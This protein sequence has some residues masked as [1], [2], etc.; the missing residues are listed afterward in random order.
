[1]Q[2]IF[3]NCMLILGDRSLWRPHHVTT[4]NSEV[5]FIMGSMPIQPR[6]FNLSNSKPFSQLKSI[7]R[8]QT[9]ANRLRTALNINTTKY[10]EY[11]LKHFWNLINSPLVHSLPFHENTS[12][13]FSYC[14]T[15]QLEDA[16]R[17]PSIDMDAFV[18]AYLNQ[19]VTLT[20]DLQHLFCSSVVLSMLFE[21][22]MKIVVTISDRTNERKGQWN[23]LKT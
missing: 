14:A 4:L 8:L 21:P 17:H 22:F 7:Q 3:Y 13:I 1:M 23:S 5:P 2:T 9:S 11:V 18:S 19:G 6:I 16:L 20:F 12:V 15:K 10:P